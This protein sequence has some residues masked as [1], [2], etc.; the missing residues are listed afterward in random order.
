MG[1]FRHRSPSHGA[2][3]KHNHAIQKCHFH[4]KWQTRVKTWLEQTMRAKRRRLNRL[5]KAAKIAPRPVSGAL[6]PAVHCPT[7][8]YNRKVRFGR[9]FT[10]DELKAAGLGAKQ[11]QS[12]VQRLKTY[13]A[14]LVVFPRR[15]KKPKSGDASTEELSKVTQL[16]GAVQPIKKASPRCKAQK[17]DAKAKSAHV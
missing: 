8:K 11:A 17:V 9:G 15:M 2:M 10:L 14:N 6:R 16:S 1:L 13:K 7:V 5:T 3:V 4:K 12:I